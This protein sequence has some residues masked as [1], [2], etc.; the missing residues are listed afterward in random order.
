MT[1]LRN[2]SKRFNKQHLV[3]KKSRMLSLLS[4]KKQPTLPNS[5]IFLMWKGRNGD[6]TKNKVYKRKEQRINKDCKKSTDKKNESGRFFFSFFSRFLFVKG[7]RHE[8]LSIPIGQLNKIHKIT[9]SI[10]LIG[11]FSCIFLNIKFINWD[12]IQLFHERIFPRK[13]WVYARF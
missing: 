9:R 10:F 3:S 2:G 6:D 5:K 7:I 4:R 11:F 8:S 12:R 1:I 13:N